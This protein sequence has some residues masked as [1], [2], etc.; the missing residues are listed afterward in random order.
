MRIMSWSAND[1]NAASIRSSNYEQKSAWGWHDEF[2]GVWNATSRA[3]Q[4]RRRIL[5]YNGPMTRYPSDVRHYLLAIGLFLMTWPVARA[6]DAPSSCFIL[7]VMISSLYGGRGPA[8]AAVVLCSAAF[9][10]YFLPSASAATP[11]R[12]GI[13]VGA[14]LLTMEV[15]EAKRRSD[16]TRLQLD[17]DFKSLAA[18]SP[19]GIVSV[20]PAGVIQ[21]AN[22]ALLNLF[23]FTHYSEIVGQS[24][25]RLLPALERGSRPRGE[26]LALSKAGGSIYVEATSG[27]FSDKTTIFL[28]DISER[29]QA[30]VALEESAASLRLTLDTLPGL[31]YTRSPDGTLEYV[32][33]RVSEYYGREFSDSRVD[34]LAEYIHPDERAD[35]AD[36]VKRHV[37]N[38]EPYTLEYRSRRNDGVYR[39][40][41][42]SV[43]PLLNSQGRVIRWYGLLT[44]VEDLRA[45]QDSLRRTQV[46]L[47]Q[48]A[49]A[50]AISELSASIVHEI[51]QPLSAMVTN[52]QAGIR[53]LDA[54]PPR[55]A[56]ART[57][58]ERVVRDGKDAAQIIAGLKSL[59]RHSAVEKTALNIA[60]LIREVVL[61]VRNRIERDEV[62]L[63]LEIQPVL[64]L[65]MGDK[66][67]L[68]QVLLNLVTNGI[69]AM[70][71]QHELRRLIIR[72]REGRD[73]VL[74]EV[75]DSGAGVADFST[76]FNPFFTTKDKGLG[77][78]LSVCKT[79]VEA[80]HGRIWAGRGGDRG[81]VF[82][83]SVPALAASAT[84][85]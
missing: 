85:E 12:V 34:S 72:A 28:R 32:N 3:I 67:Q 83:F 9:I 54:A 27:G 64:P 76:I 26:F 66:I 65:V 68:Q 5:D 36:R 25:Y 58:M 78:G 19:D 20:N 22:P 45:M 50:A 51:S 71:Q 40:V 77:M 70:D 2:Y 46:K 47:E 55:P 80:H 31:I 53:W 6:L 39:W 84:N 1:S 41:Q 15:I 38:G 33:G 42:T 16:R 56:D 4:C 44:D 14:M 60:D 69:D 81:A 23:G 75:E 48:A 37:A 21:F 43:H 10:V 62:A 17:A 74:L 57:A 24:I 73:V 35:I 7:V 13:F 49:S 8:L 18:T 30:R 63:V 52:G 11:L 82:S 79:I 59:F 61:L 29:L